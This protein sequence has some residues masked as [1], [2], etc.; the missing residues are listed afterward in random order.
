[1]VTSCVDIGGGSLARFLTQCPKLRVLGF[2]RSLAMDEDLFQ[3]LGILSEDK[4]EMTMASSLSSWSNT[5]STT[6]SPTP[7]LRRKETRKAIVAPL[8]RLELSTMIKMSSKAVSTIVQG[9]SQSLKHL[10]VDSKHFNEEFLEEIF[11]APS[12][13]ANLQGLQRLE[14]L[15]FKDGS[16]QQ[17][18]QHQQHRQHQPSS[19]VARVQLSDSD[20]RSHQQKSPWLGD[21]TTEQWILHGGSPVDD[22]FHSPGSSMD[23]SRVLP[24]SPNDR[25]RGRVL[26]CLLQGRN[27]LDRVCGR[28][29]ATP[30]PAHSSPKES[31]EGMLER[32]AVHSRTICRV[33]VVSRLTSFTVLGRDL[34]V[35]HEVWR[36]QMEKQDSSTTALST[37]AMLALSAD[38]RL[39]ESPLIEGIKRWE[40][41]LVGGSSSRV[42]EALTAMA[43]SLTTMQIRWILIFVAIAAWLLVVVNSSDSN[44]IGRTE[45]L[46]R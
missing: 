20:D 2:Y 23:H 1:M 24:S 36:R 26:T 21:T 7:P 37:S 46:N 40:S 25:V 45:T 44:G 33:I 28:Q 34:I 5:E 6:T 8:E 22:Y 27:L 11:T 18:Q 9:V 16:F 4:A 14:S 19:G 43:M 17:K 41:P 12:S 31:Y 32:F 42:P 3:G 10:S 13:S 39:R 30:I 29:P 35:E 15:S 38:A